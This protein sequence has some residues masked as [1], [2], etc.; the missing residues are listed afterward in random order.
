MKNCVTLALVFW[1][2][3]S[4]GIAQAA[5]DAAAGKAKAALCVACHGPDGNSTNPEWPNLAGQHPEYTVKQLKDFKDGRRENELMSGIAKGLSEQDMENLAAYFSAQQPKVLA[6]ADLERTKRGERL[7]RGGNS[8]R[9]VSACMSCHGPSGRGIPPRFPQISG[10][11]AAYTEKQLLA[12]KGG[13]RTNDF[14]I[15]RRIAFRMSEDEI[16]AVAQ[17]MAALY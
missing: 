9:E 15:M 13:K 16:K 7:Y 1:L 17:Y 14:E 2:S 8:E 5:G 4:L 11:H 3:V 6:V 12:F 10:Q